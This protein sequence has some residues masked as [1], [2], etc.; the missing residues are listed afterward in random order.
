VIR[1]MSLLIGMLLLSM[2][3]GGSPA[4][5]DEPCTQAPRAL[6]FGLSSAGV[7]LSTTQAGGHPDFTI[8]VAVKQDPETSPNSFGLR[9]SYSPTRNLRFNA[10]PGLIGNP[11]VLGP[12]QQCAVQELVGERRCPNGSQVGVTVID[13]YELQSKLHEPLYMMQPP[14]GDVIARLGTYAGVF[15]I[16]IDFRVRSEG[17]YGLVA[18]IRDAPSPAGLIALETT[19]WGVPAAPIHDTERCTIT[20]AALACQQSPP[21]P[22]GSRPLPFL[23]NP[24][25]C[26][27]P[28]TMG[29][30]VGSW[31]Q[32]ALDDEKE[33]KT[34]FPAI[35]G[36]N[37]LPFGP[38][39]TVT[40]TSHHTSSPTGLDLTIGLPESDGVKVLEP[41]QVRDIRIDLPPGIA[42]NPGSADGL[43]T[44]SVEQVHFGERVDAACPDASKMAGTEFEIGA[45]ARRMKGAIYLREPE[46]GNLFRIWVVA[47]DLGA[48]VKL[49]GQLEVDTATGQI[50]SV[51]LDNPQVPLR[52]VKLL[53]KSGFRAPLMTPPNCGTYFTQYDFTSWA[54][55]PAAQG[56]VPMVIDE[57][58]DTGHFTPELQAGSTEADGGQHSPFL[59][60]ITREDSE[61]NVAGFGLTL[62]SGLTATFAGIPQCV[63]V[64]AENGDCP[65]DSR[66]GKTIVADGVGS[67][68]LWVPQP[69]K[70]PTAI[71]LGGPY[72]GAPLSIIAVVPAQAGPFDLGVEV[73]RS[74]VFVD[75]I[76]AK[77]TA[78]TD[79]LP[80]RIEGIPIVYRTIHVILDRPGFTLNPTSCAAKETSAALASAAGQTASASSPYAAAN[81]SKL[82]FS[83]KLSLRLFGGTRRGAHPKLRATVKMPKNG[84][85]IASAAVSLPRSEFLENAN[86][87]TICTRVQY[88]ADDCPAASAYGTAVAHSPL[89]DFPLEGPAYLRSSS[90]PLPDLVMKLRGP[91]TMPIAVDL[92]GRVD[93]VNGGLRTTF[94]AIPDAPVSDFTLTMQGG[95]KSLI[96]NSTDL[97]RGSHRATGAFTAH[98]GA[99][100]TVHPQLKTACKKRAKRSKRP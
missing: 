39:L 16:F 17:D 95:K 10:P 45:L 3:A 63:G 70:D 80:Q 98:N 96:V 25:R 86:I 83:P 61:E 14:G 90:N 73:V 12:P 19:F 62:P 36:C 53:F 93:S 52:E 76:T 20:E 5:A 9:N 1:R 78:M 46:P 32:P 43:A 48:H 15:P 44:C 54:G 64:A 11:N 56:E 94:D 99:S 75:P 7:S 84:A 92:V 57:G 77:A 69:D 68:P 8:S 58:C 67:N 37:R 91:A 18:E 34:P 89:F 33:V 28:L 35:T 49:A 97:C 88:A 82:A 6:C 59:F 66:I 85:G 87:R 71:Y 60:T 29:V 27:A 42:I 30:N 31:T 81:C 41:A 40:P 79:P 38:A 4:A 26:G 50:K 51:V 23:T 74:A 2:A 65:S 72:K 22:P 13:A 100:Y 24:T 21:R 47:D 55:G